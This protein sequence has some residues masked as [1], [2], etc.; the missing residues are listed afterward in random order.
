METVVIGLIVGLVIGS[1]IGVVVRRVRPD[2]T[3]RRA[4]H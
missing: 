3:H 4:R 1:G 2:W